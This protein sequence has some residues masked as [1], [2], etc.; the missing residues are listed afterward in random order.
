MTLG[1][2]VLG[3]VLLLGLLAQLQPLKAADRPPVD[4]KFRWIE[5]LERLSP[6][7]FPDRLSRS[8]PRYEAGPRVLSPSG[9]SAD[10]AHYPISSETTAFIAELE[11]LYPHVLESYEIGQSWQGRPIMALRLGNENT[12]DPDDRPALYLDGQHHA[13]EAISQQIVLYTVWQLLANYGSD[14]LVTHLLD[15]RTVYAV[16][17]VN[18]DGNDVWLA[19][20]FT[21]RRTTN[22][23]ASDDDLD[24]SF[25]EDPANGMGY[26][27]YMVYRYD[28]EQEWAD[29]HPEDP[30]VPGW[31]DHFLGSEYLGVFDGQGNQVPQADDDD[32]GS[33]NEDPL[34]GVDANRNY[35]ARWDLGDA[36]PKSPFY[37]GPTVWSEPGSSAVRDFV[38]GHERLVTAL[39]YHSG[40]DMI[41]HP[42]G[43]SADADLADAVMYELLS[44]K[45]SQLTES[46][47]FLGSPHAW[48]ARE[49]YAAPGTAMD[50]LY[51]QGIYAW[52]PE[53]YGASSIVSSERMDSSGSFR[54]DVSVG[55]GFN[56][57]PSDIPQT[58]QRWDRFNTYLLAA[59]PHVLVTGVAVEDGVLDL[60]VANDGFIPV[61][62]TVTVTGGGGFEDSETVPYLQ[63]AERL[64]SID[65]PGGPAARML[66]VT[67]TAQSLAGT[68]KKEIQEERLVLW[69]EERGGA[70]LVYVVQGSVE[71][72]T[73]LGGYFGEGGWLAPRE[74]DASGIYHLGPPLIHETFLP[75]L[76][77]QQ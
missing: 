45:G 6:R 48:A 8:Q 22:P 13:R 43:W 49:L 1:R 69:I 33:K 56:P 21:Q 67:L 7:E 74:W 25:D 10:F 76:C 16:P 23:N 18:V 32:D 71:E 28:F 17:S 4:L 66:S 42:W 40:A 63:A 51:G 24:G 68:T 61:E 59:T 15:T 3:V 72:F 35:D 9:L 55:V 20:D 5:E 54:V 75:A 44:R 53:A 31:E 52:T 19:D 64:V 50:W 38:L 46:H 36:D 29:A 73:D 70:C 14:P 27:S 60:R 58:V 12:G 34:G 37:R 26:G 77:A 11:G 2:R 57:D 65:Y 41:M 30:F 47:G 62:L 39:S